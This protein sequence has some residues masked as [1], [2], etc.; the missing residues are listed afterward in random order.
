MT[1]VLVRSA[2]L[3]GVHTFTPASLTV[4]TDQSFVGSFLEALGRKDQL[5]VKDGQTQ[6][7]L[8]LEGLVAL[9]PAALVLFAAPDE[10][11]VTDAWKTSPLWRKLSVVQRGR[12]YEFNRDDW[13]RGRG[14]LA[15][16]LMVAQAT[17]SRFLQDAAPGAAYRGP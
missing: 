3:A 8:S 5:G 12:V 7:E 11:P 2:R 17:W 1:P 10:T 14:P 6:Y 13:T 4:H 16:K 15:L 9:N